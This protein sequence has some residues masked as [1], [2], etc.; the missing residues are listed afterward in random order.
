MDDAAPDVVAKTTVDVR[1]LRSVDEV[2]LTLVDRVAVGVPVAG[3]STAD[4]LGVNKELPIELTRTDADEL[5][6]LLDVLLVVLTRFDD[7]LTGNVNAPLIA[8]EGSELEFDVL[9]RKGLDVRDNV[10]LL[11]LVFAKTADDGAVSVAM[12]LDVVVNIIVDLPTDG[13]MVSEVLI[14]LK[15]EAED[16][17]IRL[18]ELETEIKP[19]DWVELAVA[20]ELTAGRLP[21]T[22]LIAVLDV[23][24]VVS[25]DRPVV[26]AVVVVT[27]DVAEKDE[28]T[29]RRLDAMT[30]GEI[31][32]PV[33]PPSDVEPEVT[34]ARLLGED[35]NG[36]VGLNM[37]EEV[38]GNELN[39]GDVVLDIDADMT[40]EEADTG[41]DDVVPGD[42][43][44]VAED[45]A[46]PDAGDDVDA[47]T[48]SKDDVLG[49]GARSETVVVKVVVCP[50]V[51]SVSIVVNTLVEL[52]VDS[53]GNDTEKSPSY[54]VTLEP[55]VPVKDLWELVDEG[56]GGD[57][58]PTI[59]VIVLVNDGI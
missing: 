26:E 49:T 22:V 29:S 19:G 5:T 45:S 43:G 47:D 46:V 48:S 31:D 15:D 32:E 13:V 16:A 55:D 14:E 25:E 50:E 23:N 18:L 54:D 6:K 21:S 33:E 56:D 1:V 11:E 3:L 51:M 41:S 37:G 34:E 58:L 2:V 39:D 35:S 10:V 52:V 17:T 44:C 4:R 24:P 20:K 53:P 36:D 59:V 7:E 27:V 30:G 42:G 28:V 12:L 57:V 9:G 40:T 38:V 8:G